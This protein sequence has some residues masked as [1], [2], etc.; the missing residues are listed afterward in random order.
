MLRESILSS[1]GESIIND[2]YLILKTN[3][4]I[5]NRAYKSGNAY[6]SEVRKVMIDLNS[7][8]VAREDAK[9]TEAK[10]CLPGRHQKYSE[11]I[12]TV[13][14]ALLIQNQLV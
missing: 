11:A 6:L 3:R 10:T 1:C 13:I 5:N 14:I 12:Q 9:K 7:I 4:V 8:K 2:L